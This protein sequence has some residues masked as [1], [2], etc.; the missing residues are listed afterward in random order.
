MDTT[1]L[2]K[3]IRAYLSDWRDTAA[4]AEQLIAARL[5]AG[6]NIEKAVDAAIKNILTCFSLATCQKF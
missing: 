2:L 5:A 1:K 6:D 3:L 4:D